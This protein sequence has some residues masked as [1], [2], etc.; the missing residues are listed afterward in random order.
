V[1]SKNQKGSVRYAVRS[2]TSFT[3]MQMQHKKIKRI[4][5]TQ[6]P[7]RNNDQY[8]KQIDPK[9]DGDISTAPDLRQGQH[10]IKEHWYEAINMIVPTLVDPNVRELY[11][12]CVVPTE[13]LQVS[14]KDL[15]EW[16]VDALMRKYNAM[17]T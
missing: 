9:L 4:D 11:K 7:S 14:K 15:I 5:S 3:N 12:W 13:T 6:S 16:N 1:Q 10:K 2:P 8:I 17:D